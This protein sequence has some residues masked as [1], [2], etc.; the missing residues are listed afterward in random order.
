MD[1]NKMYSIKEVAKLLG[2]SKQTI[3]RLIKSKKLKT[4]NITD[5][6]PRIYQKDLVDFID[7]RRDN[8]V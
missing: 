8:D 2:V 5:S 3:N 7:S 6:L 1:E 4:V